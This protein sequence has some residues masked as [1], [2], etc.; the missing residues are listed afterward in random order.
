MGRSSNQSKTNKLNRA[1]IYVE[2]LFL[3]YKRKIQEYKYRRI[4]LSLSLQFLLRFT[5]SIFWI[6]SLVALL[7][8]LQPFPFI[9]QLS[10]SQL[11]LGDTCPI[12]P[13]PR[14]FLITKE[15]FWGCFTIQASYS[16]F[17]VAD[18]KVG[19]LINAEVTITLGSAFCSSCSQGEVWK[20][21]GPSQGRKLLSEIPL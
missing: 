4:V 14:H 19:N 11:A 12:R 18:I 6:L 8:L 5:L 10:S 16:T 3:W 2:T 7:L 1:S 17:N 21:G 9:L 20:M 13:F 15:D